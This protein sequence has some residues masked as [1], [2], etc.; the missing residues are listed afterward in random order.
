MITW[1]NIC[2]SIRT[3][4]RANHPARLPLRPL[5]LRLRLGMAPD[6]GYNLPAS[7]RETTASVKEAR[8]GLAVQFFLFV[9]LSQ[10][11]M[12]A[13]FF[14]LSVIKNSFFFFVMCRYLSFV[15]HPHL[16]LFALLHQVSFFTRIY[17]WFH[18]APSSHHSISIQIQDALYLPIP[19]VYSQNPTGVLDN[20]LLLT[21]PDPSPPN[22]IH[23][24]SYLSI[25]AN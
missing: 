14:S 4:C 8:Y 12:V 6:A 9:S 18:H 20:T 2:A 13:F 19:N 24:S 11:Y 22:P 10:C 16:G 21:S 5:R 17:P 25:L 15:H 7:E 1:A 3:L 23:L